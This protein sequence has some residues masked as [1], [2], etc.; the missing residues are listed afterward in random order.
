LNPATHP[1]DRVTGLR[2]TDTGARVLAGEADH[3][4]L[5]GELAAFRSLDR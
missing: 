5:S 3:V 2:L 1:V 4:T